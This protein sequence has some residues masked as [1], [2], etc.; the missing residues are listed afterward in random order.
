MK[1]CYIDKNGNTRFC[2]NFDDLK[3]AIKNGFT[4]ESFIRTAKGWQKFS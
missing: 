3:L 1:Y 2:K 4:K